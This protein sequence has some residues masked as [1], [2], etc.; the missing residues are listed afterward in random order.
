LH[1]VR[2]IISSKKRNKIDLIHVHVLTRL[3]LLALL[4]KRSSG[5]PF[6]ITE[7]WSRYLSYVGT[8]KG[9]F[10]K[11]LTRKV[12][13]NASA[14]TTPTVNLQNAMQAHGLKNSNYLYHY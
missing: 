3:G 14:V 10:R 13:K 4:L 7:H 9:I 11:Y 5:I 8:Y 1:S 12:V 2:A 6:L